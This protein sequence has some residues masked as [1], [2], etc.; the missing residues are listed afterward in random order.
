MPSFHNR[1]ERPNQIGLRDKALSFSS[2]LLGRRGFISQTLA[3]SRT[4]TH[5][6]KE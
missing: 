4:L 1:K 2:A 6:L 3:M 5:A